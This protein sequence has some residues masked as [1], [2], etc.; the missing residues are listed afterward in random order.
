MGL[1]D[2]AIREHLELKRKHGS[3]DEELL[4]QE[5]EA[6]GPARRDFAADATPATEPAAPE[7]ADPAA[8]A[9]EPVA[10]PAGWLD[11]SPGAAPFDAVADDPLEP[12]EPV[13]EPAEPVAEAAGSQPCRA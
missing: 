9:P 3:G 2:D 1:L 5:T 8:A 11:E 6:L 4:R 7:P 10:E 13:A 12:A